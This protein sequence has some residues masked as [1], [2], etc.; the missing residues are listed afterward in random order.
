MRLVAVAPRPALRPL[1][2]VFWFVRGRPDYS[3]ERVL[4]NGVIELIVNLGQPHRVVDETNPAA[5]TTYRQAW[6]AGLQERYLV[7]E[8]VDD[9]DLIGIRFRPGGAAPFLRFSPAQVTNCVLECRDL[10]PALGD[11]LAAVRERLAKAPTVPER[12]AILEDLLL[13]HIDRDW[14]PD[15][16]VRHTLHELHKPISRIS[17]E[18]ELSHKH[19]IA[20]FR[21]QVGV[22][23]KMLHQ[24]QRF[25]SALRTVSGLSAAEV[26][27]TSV[28]Q[29]SG[30]YDQAH[31]IRAFNRF[32]GASPSTYL[33]Q[34]DADENHMVLR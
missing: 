32:A 29:R 34:R 31:L 2:E 21:G 10:S 30:Y 12:V 16:V 3:R 13:G 23:P 19:L 5:N 4:L 24:I 7:I 6:L 1:I 20:R 15:P 28:A 33:R 9:F 14:V 18:V 22:A 27:W 8:A 26:H 17:R 25:Q 11:V